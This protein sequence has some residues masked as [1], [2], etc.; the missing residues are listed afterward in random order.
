M[1][2]GNFDG[3][4]LGHQRLLQHAGELKAQH[5]LPVAVVTFEPHTLTVLRPGHA[6]PRLT[7]RAQKRRILEAAGVD[8]LVEL[9]PSRDVLD[10]TAEQFWAILRDEVRPRHLVEGRSF[11]FGKGRA[12]TV[13]KLHQWAV[14]TGVTVHI[15]EPRK[16]PLLDMQVVPASSRTTRWFIGQGR[17]RD[18]AILLGRAYEL[19]GKVVR[20]AARGRELGVPTANLQIDDQQVP[21]DGVYS[22]RCRVDDIVWPAAVSIGT[23]PTFGQNPRTVEA[24]L[25]GFSGDLYDRTLR[26]ELTDWLRDQRVFAG[27]EALKEWIAMDVQQTLARKDLDASR[28]I[29]QLEGVV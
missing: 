22:G 12:G 24:H 14:G 10:L 11:F 20:G 18:A 15:M 25:I 8:I 9:A 26:L 5:G 6:P 23:N 28:P 27:V 4:H 29:A 1:S 19:E 13:E 17:V 7:T 3:V 16:M 21:G 2:I